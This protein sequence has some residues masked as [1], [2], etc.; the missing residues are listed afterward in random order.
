MRRIIP[1]TLS[2]CL[3]S[4][5]GCSASLGSEG[6]EDETSADDEAG[7]DASEGGDEGGYSP[8]SS[9]NPCPDGQ[10]CFNGLCAIG[11][12]SAG[13]CAEGQYCA[14][15]TDMLCHDS[16]VPTCTSDS[17]CASSQL[18]VNGYCSA[19]P[20]PE[21]AGC[22][23]DD[24]LDDGCP[25]NAVCLESED[26]PELGVC[27][28][29]PACGADGSCPV[30]SIGAVCNNGYL[31]EKDA[32]CLVNLCEST[33]NCPSDWSC[34]YFDQATVGVCSSGAFGTPCST[35]EDCESGV[36]SPLPGFGAGLC[37]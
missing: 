21:D 23:L 32:I 5:L 7:D 12:L 15:D 8:C 24:Y 6:G 2:V 3:F 37:T 34:V 18:C 30:G 14:T 33:S 1:M 26:D 28:E 27:Y 22:N 25:S 11:C 9:S 20:E 17:E 29:M 16:E 13:D 31:P 35:G 10:F 19:A 4:V 36:C